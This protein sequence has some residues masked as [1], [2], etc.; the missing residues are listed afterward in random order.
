M[1][2]FWETLFGPVWWCMPVVP[3]TWKPETSGCLESWVLSYDVLWESHVYTQ[4]GIDMVN[5]LGVRVTRL[6]KGGRASPGWKQRR[7]K[8]LGS[9]AMRWGH[10]SPCASRLAEIGRYSWEGKEE[11]KGRGEKRRRFWRETTLI[12]R[13]MLSC[14]KIAIWMHR[15]FVNQ[16]RFLKDKDRKWK[17][18]KDEYQGLPFK[19]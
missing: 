6:P 5:P 1:G 19:C 9:S 2:S 4:F 8:F 13:K 14:L 17:E 16:C 12:R 10:N 15:R 11:K 18:M 3:A 7:S